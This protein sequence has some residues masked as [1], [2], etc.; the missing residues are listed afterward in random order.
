MQNKQWA[1]DHITAESAPPED[2]IPHDVYLNLPEEKTWICPL[3]TADDVGSESNIHRGIDIDGQKSNVHQTGHPTRWILHN[4]ASNPII[5]TFINSLGL[6]V[7][8]MDKLTYPAHSDTSIYPRGPVVLPNTLAVID[9]L[10]GQTFIVREYKE[11]L[12]MDA[13]MNEEKYHHSWN[14]F[15][16]VLPSTLSFLTGSR[17]ETNKGVVHVLGQPGRIL[18]KHR[19]GNIFVK[20]QLNALCPDGSVGG[21]T[22]G[23]GSSFFSGILNWLGVGKEEDNTVGDDRQG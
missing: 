3:D 2:L 14:S 17:Y 18:M 19:M 22:P 4:K 9:G 7:S 23:A 13:M 8:A 11:V 1:N 12:P 5:I 16:K 20:N 10:Q 6:E 21:D 15:K